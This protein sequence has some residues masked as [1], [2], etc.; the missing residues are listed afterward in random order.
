[1][2]AGRDGGQAEGER[3]YGG[4]VEAERK[5]DGQVEAEWNYGG[6]VEAERKAD[7]QVEAEW[8]YGGQ[9]E[10]EWKAGGDV[11]GE[12]AVEVIDPRRR[13]KCFDRHVA[14]QVSGRGAEICKG[15]GGEKLQKTIQ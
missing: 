8:N 15:N 12:E 1:M 10:A 5:A 9:V 3:N 4:Q 6:Q 11:D 14:K 7:G 2:A 13:L